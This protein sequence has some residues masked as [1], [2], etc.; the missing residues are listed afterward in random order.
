MKLFASYP[1]KFVW[2]LTKEYLRE[3]C[4]SSVVIFVLRILSFISPFITMI[5]ID[6]VLPHSQISTLSTVML[7][8]AGIVSK[9]ASAAE[10]RKISLTPGLGKI[11]R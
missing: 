6:D 1:I 7:A 8:M 4:H 2:S 9:T 11:Q 10:V 5:L 3:F